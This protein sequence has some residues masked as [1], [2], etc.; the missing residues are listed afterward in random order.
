MRNTSTVSAVGSA[1][2]ISSEWQSRLA[3]PFAYA[4]G[5]DVT[6]MRPPMPPHHERDCSRIAQVLPELEERHL[7]Q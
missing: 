2:P 3:S 7:L 6:S 4:N 1:K 5:R